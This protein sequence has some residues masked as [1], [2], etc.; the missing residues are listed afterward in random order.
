M[1][2]QLDL[3]TPQGPEDD[4]RQNYIHQL[5][6]TIDAYDP[7]NVFV[8]EALQNALDAVRQAGDRK[9][10]HKIEITMDFPAARSP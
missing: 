9:G 1:S 8:G 10:G 7:T 2:T 5:R 4:R 3:L 6:Q